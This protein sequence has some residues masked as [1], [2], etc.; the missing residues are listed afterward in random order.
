MQKNQGDTGWSISKWEKYQAFI[1]ISIK[2]M[3]WDQF[4]F[5][6]LCLTFF[7]LKFHQFSL[8]SLSTTSIWSKTII[9]SFSW[10]SRFSK[11]IFLKRFLKRF[12]WNSSHLSMAWAT[13]A[14]LVSNQR[15][16]HNLLFET[17]LKSIA[18]VNLEWKQFEKKTV[19]KIKQDF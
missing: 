5:I 14:W 3:V 9:N 15:Y 10:K 2:S 11:Q 12:S 19:S 7:V 6:V 16:L 17:N 1:P 13:D 4:S 18:Q 8:N